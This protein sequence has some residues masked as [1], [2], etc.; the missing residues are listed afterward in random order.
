MTDTSCHE[1]REPFPLDLPSQAASPRLASCQTAVSLSP[2]RRSSGPSSIS[3]TAKK[4]DL[5]LP[6]QADHRPRSDQSLPWDARR[7]PSSSVLR[8][9]EPQFRKGTGTRSEEHTSELQ[10]LRHLVCRLLLEKKKI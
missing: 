5:E 1:R 7:E 8:R 4:P 6:S 3:S 2:W 10:S 9:P